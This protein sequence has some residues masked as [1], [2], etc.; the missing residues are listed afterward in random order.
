[1]KDD[2]AEHSSTLSPLKSDMAF[3]LTLPPP[4]IHDI[5]AA[6]V[7]LGLALLWL[8][9][10]DGMAQRGSLAP[11]LSRKVIHIGT[12]PLFLLCWPL[13][14]PAASA[15]YWAALVP[16]LITLQFI[17]VGLGWLQDPAALQ[18]M[19]RHGNPREMLRGPLYYGLAFVLCTLAFWRNSPVGI[20]ALMALCGGDGLADIIGRRYGIHKLPLNPDKSWAGSVAMYI[21]SFSF[22]G[23]MLL[24]FR[25]LELLTFPPSTL[26]IVAV[27][28]LV[29]TLVEAL[30]LQEIDN[31]TLTATAVILGLWWF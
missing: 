23:G 13:F 29:V 22:A 27:I 11:K 31:L 5:V 15:R 30:P 17:A 10:M 18:A 28:T 9:L 26:A 3:A 7:T 14:S 2:E 1:M 6:V 20:V 4:P 16:L 25:H 24:W 21:G 8:R 19:T 12:G